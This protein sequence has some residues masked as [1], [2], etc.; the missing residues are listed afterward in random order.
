MVNMCRVESCR[1]PAMS[2]VCRAE[3]GGRKPTMVNVWAGVLKETCLGQ[4]VQGG[5]LQETYSDR[6]GLDGVLWETYHGQKMQGGVLQETYSDHCVQSGVSG[7]YYMHCQIV[8][9]DGISKHKPH[10][11]P[12]TNDQ[13][14][15]CTANEQN[16]PLDFWS[17]ESCGSCMYM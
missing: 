6:R 4:H 3:S 9:E 7:T 10:T 13:G 17:G 8:C 14:A 2:K 12:W 16:S 11:A 1:K 15:R 5:V